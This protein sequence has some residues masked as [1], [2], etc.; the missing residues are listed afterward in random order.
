LAFGVRKSCSENSHNLDIGFFADRG[1]RCLRHH[2]PAAAER[3]RRAREM[4]REREMERD[5]STYRH[6][7]TDTH[8][9]THTNK[10][11]NKH[12][13]AH[14]AGPPEQRKE[15]R[16]GRTRG[17]REAQSHR[18]AACKRPSRAV[19]TRGQRRRDREQRHTHTLQTL[20]TR[21]CGQM[22]LPPQSLQIARS[23]LCCKGFSEH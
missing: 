16:N 17:G 8:R 10:Q 7:K 6:R 5:V 2:S 22:L 20:R 21:L 23:R 12:T 14:Q 1:S 15:E 19:Q 13:F 9:L 4:K 18:P 11:T 3:E